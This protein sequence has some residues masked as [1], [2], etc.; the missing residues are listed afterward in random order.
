M[1]SLLP[2]F[3]FA[4]LGFSGLGRAAT[5]DLPVYGFS[6]DALEAPVGQT[7]MSAVMTFLP[8]SDGLA[9]NINVQIQ[10][11][12]DTMKSYAELSKGQFTQMNWKAISD[13]LVGDNEWVVEYAGP[14]QGKDLHFYARALAKGGKVYLVTGTATESQ[15][16]TLGDTIRKH[17]D[18][19]KL[20]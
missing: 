10:P 19:F 4:L 5:I 20:K 12:P 13:K 14:M 18:S 7:P 17:V 16:A 11:Y 2:L 1:K 6:M 15:W 9:P 3:G 8:S